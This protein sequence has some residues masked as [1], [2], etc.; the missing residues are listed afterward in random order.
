MEIT[1][2]LFHSARGY[3]ESFSIYGEDAALEAPQIEGEEAPLLFRLSA[4]GA[5]PGPRRSTHERVYVPDYGHRLPQPIARFTGAVALDARG[6]HPSVLHG[7]GH[8]GSHPHLVHEFVRS[9]VEERPPLIDEVRAADFTAP[10]ICAHESAL[11]GGE[12]V[13]IPSFA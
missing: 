2:A 9:I 12:P 6:E 5:Q 7:G 11:R 13:E 8:G 3:S 1:R 10:G 4:L